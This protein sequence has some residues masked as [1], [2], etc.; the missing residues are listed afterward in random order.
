MDVFDAI[1]KAEA[2]GDDRVRINFDN[3]A[4]MTSGMIE[5]LVRARKAANVSGIALVIVNASPNVREVFRITRLGKLF[6]F[7]DLR[8]NG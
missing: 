4:Y 8:P 6:E 1:R 5:T 2:S 3:V 7:D